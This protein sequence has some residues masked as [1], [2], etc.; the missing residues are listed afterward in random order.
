MKKVSFTFFACTLSFMII[1][2]C[3]CSKTADLYQ[4]GLQMTTQMEELIK[5]DF[6]AEEMV[7]SSD[8]L[9][10]A[11]K[12]FIANDYDSPVKVYSINVP[13][14]K[15]IFETFS[16]TDEDIWNELSDTL[17]EQ[18]L[19]KVT[20]QTMFMSINS[21]SDPD[22]RTYAIVSAYT[23]TKRFENYSLKEDITYLYMFETGK[24]I[25]VTFNAGDNE[26]QAIANFLLLPQT[27][28]LSDIREI[29]ST[30]GCTVNVVNQ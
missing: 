3:G 19:N 18:I 1:M 26:I 14:S 15:T 16:G 8:S 11:R 13:D 30:F 12:S 9:D 20:A 28:T 29:F 5:S 4:L 22:A 23:V 17:K 6:Y 2:L 25:T 7:G 24:P 27:S 21:K 10:S